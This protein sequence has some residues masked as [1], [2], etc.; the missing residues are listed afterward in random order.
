MIEENVKELLKELEGGNPLGEKVTLVAATKTRSVEEISRAVRAGIVDIGENRAQEF[1]EKYGKIAG[2]KYHFIG[3]LQSNKLK[4]LVGKAD[5]IQSVDR[6]EIALGI[7]RL[8]QKRGAVQQILLEVNTGEAAK[9]GYPEASVKEAYL[10]LKEAEGI[11][12]RGLFA[13][14]PIGEEAVLRPIAERMRAL[15]EEIRSL[16]ANATVLSMG[17]SGDWRLCV[18]CGSNMVRLGTA[19]FGTRN[20]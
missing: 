2:A 7:A 15:F 1:R 20:G 11:A 4:Y 13:M 12:L 8:A 3:R 10:R 5:L 9:G 17:M 14:L 19:I 18:A 6:D 16:D